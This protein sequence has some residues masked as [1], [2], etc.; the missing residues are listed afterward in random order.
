MLNTAAKLDKMGKDDVQNVLFSPI[1]LYAT[2]ALAYLGSGERDKLALQKVLRL[3]KPR[4]ADRKKRE[5]ED[6]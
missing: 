2:T 3:K 4:R 6:V 5:L 1:D